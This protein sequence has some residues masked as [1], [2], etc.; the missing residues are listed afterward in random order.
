[1][2]INWESFST[3]NQDARGI[4]F[5]FED[6]CRQIFENEYLVQNKKYR[7]LHANPNN[8]GLETEPIYDEI[9]NRWIGFQA[10]FFEGDVHYDQIKH[11]AE[12]TVEYYTGK[13]GI[14]NCVYLFCNRPITSTSDGYVNAVACLKKQN[15]EVCLV[16]D[17]AILDVVRNKYPY[18]GLYYFGNHTLQ[19]D[20]FETH[21]KQIFDELGERYNKKFNVDT[22]FSE[23]LSL[24]IHDAKAVDYLNA[25]KTELLNEITKL[26]YRD[27]HTDYLGKLKQAV[28][29][30][31]EID[32]ET[33]EQAFEWCD[34]IKGSVAEFLNDFYE[35]IQRL[36]EQ[37]SKVYKFL[38]NSE[39]K[40]E[41]E[42]NNKEYAKLVSEIHDITYLMTLPD[43]I[44]VLGRERQ[45]LTGDVLIIDGVAGMG[46]SQLLASKMQTIF[47]DERIGLL[48]VAGIY[49]T[50]EPIYEQI[51]KNL[52]LDCSFDDLIDILEAIGEK[53][54]RIVPIF[55]DALNETWNTKLWKTGLPVIVNKIKKSP[56]VKLVIS[57]RTEYKKL[58]LPDSVQNNENETIIMHHTGFADNSIPAI[59]A[60]L[61]YYNIPFTPLQ[62]FG[63]EMTNPLFLTLYCKTYNGEE[64]S[65][66]I[67]YNRLIENANANIYRSLNKYLEENGYSENDIFLED[68][69][70]EIAEWFIFHNKKFIS[71][72]ELVSLNFWKEYNLNAIPI[73]H[74][75][76]K[77][78]ILC[79]SVW[80]EV[81]RFYF[82]YDQMND[83]YCAKAIIKSHNTKQEVYT[84]L[85]EKVLNIQNGEVGNLGNIDLF[86]NVCAL[87]AEKYGEE[88]IAI[89]DDIKSDEDTYMVFSRYIHSFQWREA[90]NI[91]VDQFEKLLQN[92][93]CNPES[94]W[95]MLIGNSVKTLN[96]LNA[97]F[98]HTFLKKYSLSKRD[99]IWTIYINELTG[100][101]EDRLVQLIQM[102]NKGEKLESSNEKQIELLLTLF[103]WLLTS[104]SRWLRDYASKAMIEIL[105]DHFQL[106]QVILNKFMDVNDTYIIQRL[107]GIVF[108]A[109]CKK[110]KGEKERFRVLSEYV[111]YAVFD[112]KEVY[113]D[114]LLR[115][116]AR[117]IIERFLYENSDYCGAIQR[118]KI[119]P[120]YS[121]NN[122]PK[123][124]D[125]HYLEKNYAGGMYW[126]IDSMKFEGM[127]I[128]GDFGRYVFQSALKSFDVDEKQIWNYAVYY[129]LTELGYSEEYFG[130]Y[131][132][133][134]GGGRNQTIK[135]ERIGKKYQWIMMYNI[136][137]RIS[138]HYKMIDR[139]NIPEKEDIKYE[140]TWEPFI[141]DF[142]PTLNENFMICH[143]APVFDA[144][145]EYYIKVRQEN[146]SI[147]VS[148]FDAQKAW[149]ETEGIF[150]LNMKD[151]MILTDAN[152]EKWVSLT[153]YY[154]TG[155][156]DSK[157][158]NH[159]FTWSWSYAYFVS[160]E[161]ADKL[162][163]CIE[164][165]CS[166]ITH[167]T[168]SFHEIYT[169]Y[170]REY[171]WAPSCQ[172]V[173]K[174]AWV[175][176][177]IE[178]GEYETVTETVQ[179]PDYSQ[180]DAL[181]RK[182]ERLLGE[183]DVNSSN[184]VDEEIE[185]FEIPE[186]TYKEQIIK[187]KVK[188]KIGT[189]LHATT[190]LLWEAEY[191]A[192]KNETVSQ[193]VPCAKII[194]TMHLR[195]QNEDGIYYDQNGK[196]AAFDT[197]RTQ[198]VNGVVIRKDVLDEFL[199]KTKM[200]LVWLVDAEK[201]IKRKD[202]MCDKWSDWE[203]VYIY[204][205]DSVTGK[206][207]R[208]QN[209]N[210]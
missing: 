56:M 131:D 82:S 70:T 62:Y 170:N 28:A 93:P 71:K 54:K 133:R 171:P 4:R 39:Q 97:D 120:P 135:V 193:R 115:D 61:N 165:G 140:G 201:E 29:D 72:K 190:D 24:F 134:C 136:L 65:L 10:K 118:T 189:I 78:H 33:L 112:Q 85:K 104:S 3:Y 92:Y 74:R 126:L 36:E 75:L 108:G 177:E 34:R 53:D 38:Q 209:N 106:C 116:Y 91:P 9:N 101:D 132:K 167:D 173:E 175:E 182:Y 51:M 186:I 153:T 210:L 73:I 15:I 139:W 7:Y 151:T 178:T 155:R 100:N 76:E 102:Y 59:R 163:K 13:E 113:P 30:I 21:N 96:P 147:D 168:A 25:K 87:F 83:Y 156:E 160:R 35:K 192:T 86:A 202:G 5:K 204:E 159:L 94:V 14:V 60:F 84:F 98:L 138:D 18:L 129:I 207:R 49:Y 99:Y 31:E 172:E 69:I 128:Y 188:E 42:K 47:N 180:L 58:V 146:R 110:K 185:D 41:R 148:S 191:D 95:T 79:E 114:I 8:H 40:Q 154:D 22:R 149:L 63:Y 124:A 164:N 57:Y 157:F 68:L 203:A 176:T 64:V 183:E 119:V 130:E 45:L 174:Y 55:I 16:T 200:K 142:D 166:V 121:S 152:G 184:G 48:L 161:Q 179:V 27:S 11:S 37:K 2:Q 196:L 19:L 46:K 206:I 26:Y 88:C 144:L 50:N 123:I 105:K 122:I 111:Y 143:N 109:C 12:K 181:L 187:R 145:N 150:F 194:E 52:R 158:D 208:F 66:P 81:E 80:D 205:G 23:E 89:I 1:M 44:E 117:L 32:I 198:N 127:G 162:S 17:T 125:Q 77:E 90:K 169:V 137:A 103:G 141:R 107:Y 199:L 197:K 43:K 20:W 67:L 6:L 195:Q